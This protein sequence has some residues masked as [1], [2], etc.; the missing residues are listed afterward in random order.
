MKSMKWSLRIVGIL[1]LISAMSS[2][3]VA[4]VV[5]AQREEITLR[6]YLDRVVRFNEEIEAALIGIEIGRL[7][8]RGAVAQFE[9]ALVLRGERLQSD[10]PN[11]VEE[12]RNLGG[13]D[14]FDQKNN[15]YTAGLEW[16]APTGANVSFRYELRDLSNN[17]QG[18]QALDF[19]SSSNNEFVTFIGVDV[20]QPILRG[21]GKNVTFAEIRLAAAESKIAYEEL[22]RQMMVI[23][24]SAEAAYWNLYYAQEQEGFRLRSLEVAKKVLEDE[25]V[26]FEAGRGSEIDVVLAQAAISERQ[27]SLVDASFRRVEASNAARSFF[28][29]DP[30]KRSLLIVSDDPSSSSPE[31]DYAA[32]LGRAMELNPD[33]RGAAIRG[34]INQIR[35]E[36]AKNQ[37][38]PEVNLLASGGFNG[39]G[40]SFSDSFD[41]VSGADFP[42]WSIGVEFRMPLGNRRATSSL[43]SVR[44]RGRQEELGRLNLERQVGSSIDNAIAKI[45][46]ANASVESLV[47]FENANRRVLESEIESLEAGRGSVRRVIEAE[48][49]LFES[50]VA[51]IRAKVQQQRARLELALFEGTVL[52]NSEADFSMAEIRE[53]TAA[54]TTEG[55]W[56]PTRY[57]KLTGSLLTR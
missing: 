53:K 25:R 8:E 39:L 1:G 23:L 51:L 15:L 20:T 31:L 46:A 5:P 38:L 6:E 42:V 32:S 50:S 24:S 26:R 52:K 9:P 36:F 33:L 43:A 28:S 10:R 27:A 7:G 3:S 14:R 18:S 17:L 22:R 40:D 45:L 29:A 48:D 55:G 57:E 12:R 56:D 47:A 44:L 11:T 21:F 30:A 54:M 41:D 2:P 16:F 4:Q 49:N 19:E 37:T 34:E 13:I 35:T